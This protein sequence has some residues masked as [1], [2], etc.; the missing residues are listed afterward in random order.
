MKLLKPQKKLKRNG[1]EQPLP[2]KRTINKPMI[3]EEEFPIT[4]LYLLKILEC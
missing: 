4:Y 1:K 3:P 2:I